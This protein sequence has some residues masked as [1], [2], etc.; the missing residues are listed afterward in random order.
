M[1]LQGMTQLF[2]YI[3]LGKLKFLKMSKCK[4]KTQASKG[5]WCFMWKS[6]FKL[7]ATPE[8]RR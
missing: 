4:R 3:V 6:L 5:K 1:Q 2:F 7:F 8:K